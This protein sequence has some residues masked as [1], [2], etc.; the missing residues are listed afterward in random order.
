MIAFHTIAVPHSDIVKKRLTMD[1]FAADLWDTF[2]GKGS[3][4]YT[5]PKTFFKKTHM[6]SNLTS[7]LDGVQKRLAG[8]GGDGFQHLE[9]PFGGGK[10][11]ALIAMYHKAIEWKAKCVVIVGTVMGP[12]DTVWGKIEEQLDGSVNTLAGNLAPGREKLRRVL[13]KHDSVL[14]LIDELLPYLSVVSGVKLTDT[15]LATQTLTFIQQL[16]EVTSTLNRVCVVASFPASVYDMADKKMADEMLRMIRMV[17]SRKERKIIPVNPDDVPNIIRSRLFSSSEDEI[18]KNSEETISSFVDYCEKESIL[19]PTKTAVQYRK[20]FEGTY[21]FLPEVIDVLYHKWGS[22]SSFQR[23]RGVLRLLS[24]VIHSLKDSDRPYITLADFDLRNDEIRRELLDHIGPEFDSVISKDITS[25][26]SGAKRVDQEVGLSHRGLRL[27]TRA[28]TAI[29]MYSFS[30]G[31]NGATANQIKMAACGSETISSIVGDIVGNFRN[32]MS[33]IKNEDDRYLFTSEPNI[34]RL[35]IDKMEGITEKEM[36]DN[37]KS[38]LESNVGAQRV[39]TRVWPAGPRDIDDSPTLKLAIMQD[40]DIK[41]CKEILESKGDMPRIHRNSIFFLCPSGVERGQFAEV[42]K[43]RIAL[44]KISSDSKTLKPSQKNDIDN[45][46]KKEKAILTH[47]IRKYYRIL[48]IP[49]ADGLERHDLGIPIVGD[50]KGMTEQVFEVL[51]SQQQVH[52]S[53]GPLVIQDEYLKGQE[54]AKTAHMYESMLSLRGSRRPV[55]RTVIEEAIRHGVMKKVFGLG[56][57]VDGSPNCTY[58]GDEPTIDFT[59][60]EVII[61]ATICKT[62]M[63]VR[64]QTS[65]ESPNEPNTNEGNDE[66][67]ENVSNDVSVQITEGRKEIDFKFEIPEGRMSDA[68]GMLQLINSKF[69]KIQFGIKASNGSITKDD[70]DNMREALRQMGSRHDLK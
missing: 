60:N 56:I 25:S 35:K 21:P 2:Q 28:A 42:L 52:D 50:S 46:L 36:S 44:E 65:V 67:Y 48:Y 23:T 7:I 5:D 16:S 10:T 38:L 58:F 47:L 43:S 18:R 8:D 41:K 15:T 61:N 30:R 17:S 39:R 45:D 59:D 33:Y 57:F 4:E 64:V 20:D 22:F 34:N 49:V 1:V 9:T 26:D 31:K 53:I 14:I 40:D 3:E 66:T 29:F 11:H 6:T 68:M 24:I 27:A 51:K 69:R 55:N 12:E 37:E 13:E 54:F 19:P 63:E 32:K 70:L 62:Q